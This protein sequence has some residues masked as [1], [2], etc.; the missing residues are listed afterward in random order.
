MD[1]I[2]VAVITTSRAD[3]GLLVPL[4]KKIRED[5]FFDFSLIVTGSHL[6]NIHGRT[7][8][9]IIDD[10]FTNF[11]TV[12]TAGGS[13][14][15]NGVCKSIA[16]GVCGFSKIYTKRKPDLII[17]LGDR[18]ELWPA[19]MAAVVH[20]VPIAHL[21]GGETTFGA[22]DECIRHSV[23]KMSFLHF[24]SIEVYAKRIVQ[25]GEDPD[26]VHV[27]GALGID[28]IN[29]I[30][31]MGIDELKA[32]TGANFKRKVALM[33]YHPVTLDEYEKGVGQTEEILNALLSIEE[34]E[35]LITAPNMD[36]GNNA[37]INTIL[38]YAALYPAKFKFVKSLG[39]RAYLSSLKY[40]CLMIGNSS[41]GIIESASF[42]LPVVNIGDRQA[43][44]LK[45]FNVIDCE[46]SMKSIKAAI[47]KAMSEEFSEY[48]S[49]LKN[50]Y[51][52]GKTAER[53]IEILKQIDFHDKAR[54]L[55]KK[56]FDIR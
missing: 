54:L 35:V 45:P 22:I 41:S 40:S 49:D 17:V 3:Y 44:R 24:P 26:R 28:N 38:R 23:T 36:A 12:D 1:K 25:M 43:G 4:M 6:S 8:E 11:D 9:R 34:L 32:Y 56:F 16:S 19:C 31:L 46:C 51:G 2:R 14:T 50:P 21:H 7:V 20:K 47:I 53:I 15:E 42:K 55:K 18:Y 52:D 13:D 39:Q 48:I 29:E 10:G 33:T 30:D 37:I 5:E 27:V